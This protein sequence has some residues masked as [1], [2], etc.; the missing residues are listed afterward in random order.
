MFNK[1]IKTDKHPL[2]INIIKFQ[3]YNFDFFSCEEVVLFEYLAVKGMSFK[4][5]NEFYHST[6]TITRETGIKKHSLNSILS[7]FQQLGILDVEVKGFPKVKH[8]KVNFPRIMDLF[9]QIYQSAENGKLPSDFRKLLYDFFQ[10]L[11][12]NY[13]QKNTIKNNKI[14]TKKET[15]DIHS[16]WDNT[17]SVFNEF[18]FSLHS[19][20]N[21]QQKQ[22]T[23][24]DSKL[25]S[26]CKNYGADEVLIYV[27]K[28][29]AEKYLLGSVNDFLKTSKLDIK[30]IDYIEKQL[31]TEKKEV[32]AFIES[33]H[34]IYNK[35]RE[36]AGDKKK[37]FSKTKLP[38]N[39]AIKKQISDALKSKSDLEITHAFIAYS[40]KVLKGDI[41]PR[42]F[43]P[44]FFTREYGDY[45]VINDM[46]DYFNMQY[47]HS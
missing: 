21:I 24:E 39:A 3:R 8:F 40:D 2:A 41:S 47:S 26:A 6:T 11:A 35:R 27:K 38:I 19:E 14:E 7:R 45:K 9:S 18:F 12:D 23:Y 4:K 13:L 46:L 29:F 5:L 10:P 1:P 37:K 15:I 22:L 33:L 34:D 42:K 25:Y 44:Y 30:K 31:A 32:D 36:M 20:K 28:Y 17:V 43:L 16:D